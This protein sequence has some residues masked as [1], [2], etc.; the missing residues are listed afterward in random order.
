MRSERKS[1]LWWTLS[2]FSTI[3]WDKC[4][5]F[6]KSNECPFFTKL[7][8][9]VYL[10]SCHHD[11][12]ILLIFWYFLL[13]HLSLCQSLSEYLTDLNCSQGLCF[14]VIF[15]V[16]PSSRVFEEQKQVFDKRNTLT[17]R[18][19]CLLLWGGK[20]I[21]AE[22]TQLALWAANHKG[23]PWYTGCSVCSVACP[24]KSFACKK[25]PHVGVGFSWLPVRASIR[26]RLE[27]KPGFFE[28]TAKAYRAGRPRPRRTGVQSPYMKMAKQ[29]IPTLK[30]ASTFQLCLLPSVSGNF[31]SL[32]SHSIVF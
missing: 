16:V 10:E 11:P 15:A 30:V 26:M 18:G 12:V 4:P 8:W 13:F 32:G 9:I 29:K 5:F 17:L 19:H 20:K 7:P 6:A 28:S 22:E 3:C 14:G 31:K 2:S 24:S 25:K 21:S 1:F 27:R 23:S